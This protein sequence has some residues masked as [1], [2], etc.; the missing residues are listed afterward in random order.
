M[1]P[2]GGGDADGPVE[3][4]LSPM[5]GI[6][7]NIKSGWSWSGFER[8]RLFVNRGDGT[9]ESLSEVLGADQIT[10]GRA[11]AQAD[12]DM[13]GD[14]DLLLANRN[15]PTIA[16][17]RNDVPSGGHAAY[18]DLRPADH[19]SPEGSRLLATAGGRTMRRD[20][21][22]GAGL[23]SQQWM[24]QHF[25]LADAETIELLEVTWP[26]GSVQI[27][28]DIPA[29]HYVVLRQGDAGTDRHPLNERNWTGTFRLPDVEPDMHPSRIKVVK[30]RKPLLNSLPWKGEDGRMAR[31][32]EDLRREAAGTPLVLVNLWATWCTNCR[33][34]MPE[35]I[36]LAGMDGDQVAVVGLS[37]DDGVDEEVIWRVARDWGMEYPVGWLPPK[38]VGV[39]EKALKAARGEGDLKLPTSILM[40]PDGRIRA[41][42][43]GEIDAEGVSLYADR[44][45]EQMKRLQRP[46]DSPKK[47]G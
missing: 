3:L 9:F 2:K 41:I 45:V 18:F 44:L 19:R 43:E 38:G 42:I 47:G 29:D 39:L 20:V 32:T 10:D 25:G 13:D 33:A 30:A 28:E 35:V 26:D 11:I 22:V 21:F 27:W 37:V 17:L 6:M 31:L 23:L 5:S 1:T 24:V 4:G 46:A 14:P 12:F 8:N 16:V 15:R 34:E 36:R 40:T 7:S